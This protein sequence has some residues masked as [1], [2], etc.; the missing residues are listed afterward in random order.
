M[1]ALYETPAFKPFILSEAD[2]MISRENIVVTQ[3]GSAVESGTV[4]TQIKTATTCTFAMK[5]GSTGNPTAGTISVAPA[6]AKVGAYLIRFRSATKFDVEDPTGITIGN[7]TVGTAFN[8]GGVTFTL[9]AG[10]TAAVDGD[11]ATFTVAAGSLKYIPYT[12][13]AAAGSADAVLY[14][15]LP[16]ATGD[17]KAVGIT[18]HAELNRSELTGLDATAEAQLRTRGLKVRGVSTNGVSTPAL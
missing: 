2:E 15:R 3:S 9:T 4:L 16:A 8:K 13:N 11:E 18:N 17:A 14:R 1:P 10:G 6:T 12:A 5:A 7:G